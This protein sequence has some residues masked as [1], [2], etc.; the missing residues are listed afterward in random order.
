MAQEDEYPD[1]DNAE[2][3][4]IFSEHQLSLSIQEISLAR[5]K[6]SKLKLCA[7]HLTEFYSDIWDLEMI[8]RVIN[9]EQIPKATDYRNLSI[10]MRVEELM[11]SEQLSYEKA[12]QKVADRIYRGTDAVKKAIRLAN[13]GS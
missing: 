11:E 5:S 13:K 4:R 2:I 10:K 12:V 7:Q 3:D 8:A 6:A 9:G 1:T